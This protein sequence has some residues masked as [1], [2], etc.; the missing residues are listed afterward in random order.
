MSND[1]LSRRQFVLTGAAATAG[2]AVFGSARGIAAATAD[3]T[4]GRL[5]F[6]AAEKE[7]RFD[8]GVLRGTLRREG[9]SQGLQPVLE[10]ASGTPLAGAFGLFSPYRLLTPEV[11][12]GTAAWDWPSRSQRLSDGAVEVLWLPDKVHPL[13][14]KAV[15]RFAAP[16][17]LDF[18]ATVKPQRQLREF[19]LFL[20]SYFAGFPASFVYVRHVPPTGEKPGFG[21]ATK[22]AGDW[23]MFPR[24]EEAVR[25]ASDGRW[26]H[27][28]NPVAWKIMHRLAAPLA[29]RRDAKSGLTAVLMAPEEDCFAVST[30]YGEEGHRSVYL[31]LFGRDLK[32]GE[33]ASARARMVVG[34]AIA[35]PQAV[36]LYE[37]F[38][39]EQK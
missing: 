15:Y 1:R 12:F 3:A 14:L 22:Q 2:A 8:T 24:D 5:A 39:K 30:P 32:A 34:K 10:I 26:N 20:A 36:E 21:E 37:A 9:K 27:P 29:L 23:Q 13:E 16:N 35:D 28:P 38:R 6:T 4:P 11:R 19:E 25:I 33:T 17:V 7:Y 18:H 31:S